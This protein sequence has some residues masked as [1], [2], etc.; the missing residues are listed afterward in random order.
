MEK[1]FKLHEKDLQKLSGKDVIV[2]RLNVSNYLKL[3]KIFKVYKIKIA[4]Y[5]VPQ[6]FSVMQYFIAI[7]LGRHKIIKSEE[8]LRKYHALHQ[9]SV[10][11]VCDDNKKHEIQEQYL[12]EFNAA[13]TIISF[14]FLTIYNA[15]ILKL[16]HFYWKYKCIDVIL[17]RRQLKEYTKNPPEVL[18]VICSPQKTADVTLCLTFDM[19]RKLDEEITTF[20]FVNLWHTPRSL[21]TRTKNKLN[22]VKIIVGV[23]DPIAQNLSVLY[24]NLNASGTVL[25]WMCLEIEKNTSMNRCNTIIDKY[26][27][28][29]RNDSNNIQAR[30]DLYNSIYTSCSIDEKN[31]IHSDY[32]QFFVPEFQKCQIDILKYPFDQEKGYGIIQEDNIEVFVYQLERLNNIIPEMS[33]WLEVSFDRLENGNITE[34]KWLG[35]SYQQALKEIQITQ[36]YF[37][38]C[39]NEPYVTHCYSQSDI[40]KFKSRWRTHIIDE[41]NE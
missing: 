26:E 6:Q 2:Y 36:E 17:R 16:E 27:K 33:N 22:K 40:E 25:P 41:E 35:E 18:N 23:R 38:C 11:Y 5:Y 19:L 30:F 14:Q 37:D 4:G 31:N 10:I 34:N 24:Q 12:F 32:I 39:Y 7:L 9:S 13:I 21:S 28:F 1:L 3:A 29:L 8:S 15:T 20:Q